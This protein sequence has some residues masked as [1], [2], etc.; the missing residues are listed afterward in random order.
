MHTFTAQAHAMAGEGRKAVRMD[1]AME[2]HIW[3]V[4]VAERVADGPRRARPAGQL[5]DKPVGRDA[6]WRY[7][8]CDR[9]D[10]APPQTR[11]RRPHD[12]DTAARADRRATLT[13][14]AARQ[15]KDVRKGIA[16]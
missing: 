3:L 1:D 7:A 14:T 10:V 4:A 8:P 9:V 13:L 11:G 12:A 2:R 15:S 16:Q 6:P 5:A